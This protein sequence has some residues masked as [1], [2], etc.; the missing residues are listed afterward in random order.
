V[1]DFTIH[2][3]PKKASGNK[4]QL[5]NSFISWLPKKL[6]GQLILALLLLLLG[7]GFTLGIVKYGWEMGVLMLLTIIAL[8]IIYFLIVSPQF[9]IITYLSLAY[10]IMWLAKFTN[11]FPVGTI[12]DGMLVFFILGFFIKQKTNTNWMVFKNSISL[13]ISIWILYNIGEGL[14]PV[15]DSIMAWLYTVRTVAIIALMYFIFLYHIS[16][17]QFLKTIFKWWLFASILNALYAMKQEYLGFFYFEKHYLELNPKM[18]ALLFQGGHWRKFS[19]NPDPVTFAFNMAMASILCFALITGPLKAYRKI[20]L[21]FLAVLFFYVMLFSGTRSAYPL[22][23]AALFL[24]TILKFNKQVV[25]YV[26][27]GLLLIVFLI[28]VPTTNGT[29]VRFQSAFQP[30]N[31]PSYQVRLANQ[32]KIKPYIYAHPFGGGLGATGTWGQKFSP[33]S[34]LANFPPDSGYVRVVV[35]LGWVGLVVFSV[36][37]FVILQYGIRTYFKIRD[38]ELKS[39]ALAMLLIVF[40]WNIANYPQEALVQYPSNVLFFLAIAIIPAIYK[41]DQQQNLAIDAKS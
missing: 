22:I 38:P 39:Y 6:F 4:N 3:K 1:D 21:A 35:E 8:P 24:L 9:G 10:I 40:A 25:T 2:I 28:F 18:A 37:I 27:T 31:D 33:N 36:M 29:I 15:A 32:A 34:Y 16:T 14:N 11:D 13:V 5:L 30:N 17:K 23:P 41:I 12:M 20:I 26:G 19:I 7:I